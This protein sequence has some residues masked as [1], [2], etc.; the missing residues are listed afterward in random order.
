MARTCVVI[1]QLDPEDPFES[2]METVETSFGILRIA[3]NKLYFT[4]EL[5]DDEGNEGKVARLEAIFKH[6]NL[7][8]KTFLSSLAWVTDIGVGYELVDYIEF[9]DKKLGLVPTVSRQQTRRRVDSKALSSTEQLLPLVMSDSHLLWALEDYRTALRERGHE[10]M[11][12]HRSI[13]WLKVRFGTW[14]EVWGTIKSTKKEIKAIKRAAN[15]YYFAR[16]AVKGRQPVPPQVLE[17]AFENTRDILKK[18][19]DWLSSQAVNRT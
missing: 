10:L 15:H 3:Q 9:V 2:T 16:H 5:E 7:L 11:F 17:G 19:M 18:Y 14:E 13:E 6:V 8:L 4:F 12:L 1:A